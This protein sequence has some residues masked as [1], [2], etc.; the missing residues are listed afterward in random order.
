V[1]AAAVR[2][3]RPVRGYRLGMDIDWSG[4]V[5]EQVESHWRHRLRPR[6]DGLTDDEYVGFASTNGKLF[7][8]CQ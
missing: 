5:V 8:C 7:G 2:P 3:S 4:E 6:L 1:V